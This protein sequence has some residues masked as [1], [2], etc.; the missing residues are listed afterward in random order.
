MSILTKSSPQSAYA[1]TVPA[2]TENVEKDPI[3]D[4]I[5]HGDKRQ[6]ASI[7]TRFIRY[8][9]GFVQKQEAVNANV[10]ARLSALETNQATKSVPVATPVAQGKIERTEKEEFEHSIHLLSKGFALTHAQAGRFFDYCDYTRGLKAG[11][12]ILPGSIKGVKIPPQGVI[13]LVK[14]FK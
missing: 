6:N 3:Y 4:A 5:I 12:R 9:G 2:S 7:M 10:N 11:D 14:K 1:V 8:V 13:V